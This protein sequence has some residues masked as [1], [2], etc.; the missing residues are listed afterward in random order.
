MLCL[1]WG[2]AGY[3]D[4]S[5]LEKDLGDL[6]NRRLDMS[7]QCPGAWRDVP[8]LGHQAQRGHSSQGGIVLLYLT[9]TAV[10]SSRHHIKMTLNCQGVCKGVGMG[11]GLEGLLRSS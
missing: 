7:Q 2:S 1:G 9:W 6:G 4:I 5:D 8:V 11:K 3:M 10:C